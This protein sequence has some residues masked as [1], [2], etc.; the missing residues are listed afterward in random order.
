MTV[1]LACAHCYKDK[2]LVKLDKQVY[3]LLV[4]LGI[5]RKITNKDTA[6]MHSVYFILSI[7]YCLDSRLQQAETK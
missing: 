5:M 1:V 4:S 3:K 2:K 6:M 7:I